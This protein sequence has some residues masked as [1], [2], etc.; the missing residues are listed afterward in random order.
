[1]LIIDQTQCPAVKLNPTMLQI[2]AVQLPFAM[3]RYNDSIARW[4]PASGRWNLAGNKFLKGPARSVKWKLICG[5]RVS[6]Q[7]AQHFTTHFDHQLVA[8][9]VCP[10]GNVTHIGQTLWIPG[11]AQSAETKLNNILHTIHDDKTL[12]QSATPHIVVLLIEKKDQELYSS[13]KYLADTV[14]YFQAICA[15]EQ[16][17]RHKRDGWTNSNHMRQY[18]ANVAMKANLK[19]AG[20]NHTADGVSNWLDKTLVIGSDLTHPGNGAVDQCPSI[21]AVVS[22]VG[23]DG[24]L[25]YGHLWL[26]RKSDVSNESSTIRYP[27]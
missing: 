24:G 13:F 5:Q 8:T 19:F 11:G 18:M 20:I 22:S 26:Q 7:A 2:P 21:A 1:M 14:Y 9:G 4:Q 12:D 25:F 27:S 16:N 15:T 17:F 3:V 23:K 10:V 6:Q